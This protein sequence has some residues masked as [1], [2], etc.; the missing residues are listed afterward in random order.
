MTWWLWSFG[1]W[2]KKDKKKPIPRGMGVDR[3]KDDYNS[4]RAKEVGFYRLSVSLSVGVGC[5]NTEGNGC[6]RTRSCVSPAPRTT[7]ANW[8]GRDNQIFTSSQLLPSLD[9]R[10]LPKSIRRP[11]TD[12]KQTI[13]RKE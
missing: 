4:S 13:R 1:L 8:D 5:I 11:A 12:Q 10:F 2:N 9:Q 3:E 7:D 6:L